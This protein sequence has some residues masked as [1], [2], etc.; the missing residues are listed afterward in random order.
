VDLLLKANKFLTKNVKKNEK[1][2]VGD[3][4]KEEE[5]EEEE[6]VKLLIHL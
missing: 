1:E 5:E 2:N 6:E 3:K 4:K